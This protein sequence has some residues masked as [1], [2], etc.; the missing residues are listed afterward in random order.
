VAPD[1]AAREREVADLLDG[2]PWDVGG[3]IIGGYAIAAFGAPRY[4]T[5]IDIVVKLDAFD[6]IDRWLL[7]EKLS[8]GEL[9]E[10]LEQN[11]AGK[12]FRYQRGGITVDILPGV[13]RDREADVDIPERWISKDPLK[14]KLFLLET[15]T[16]T[17][18]P[19]CRLTAFW[20]LKLQAGREKDLS[21]LFMTRD[22]AID[23]TDIQEMFRKIHKPTLG[24]KLRLVLKRLD[25]PKI[26]QDAMSRLGYAKRGKPDR[27]AEWAKFK[28]KVA[29][30]VEPIIQK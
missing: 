30:V 4:S 7:Q 23:A 13:V 3:V 1:P 29:A 22:M 12:G 2:W 20:A 16:R 28:A 11:Y 6:A 5:D 25:E 17:E 26:F 10:S 19:V 14:T 27:E 15:S 21:D 8:R 18:V 9:P 24:D